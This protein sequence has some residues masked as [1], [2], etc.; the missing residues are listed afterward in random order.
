MKNLTS[1]SLLLAEKLVLFSAEELQVDRVI[2]AKSHALSSQVFLNV[3]SLGRRYRTW[4]FD[5]NAQLACG[6]LILVLRGFP[7]YL[8]NFFYF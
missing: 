8:Q 1:S 5:D 4:Q 3:S 6:E 2:D 7:S